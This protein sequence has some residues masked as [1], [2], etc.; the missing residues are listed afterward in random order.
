VRYTIEGFSQAA[1]FDL[2]LDCVDACILRWFVDFY[3]T[4]KMSKVESGG[5]TYMWVQYQACIDDLPLMR[6][7]NREVLARRFRKMVACGLMEAYVHK[8]GGIYTCYRLNETI[9]ADLI[10]TSRGVDSKVDRGRLKSREGVDSKVET[11]DSYTNNQSIK[12]NINDE[13]KK[14]PHYKR[15]LKALKD[16]FSKNYPE[17]FAC[18]RDYQRESGFITDMIEYAEKMAPEGSY[19][20]QERCLEVLINTAL[21]IF[22]GKVKELAWMKGSPPIPSQI[23]SKGR[24]PFIIEE[25]TRRNSA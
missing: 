8:T 12:S 16:F 18:K 10:E 25:I 21:D 15:H 1:M 7:T 11:K 2:G 4:G 24:R 5:K 17:H 9:F 20:Q 6:V 14:S 22:E 13:I 23:M 3:Q 19:E